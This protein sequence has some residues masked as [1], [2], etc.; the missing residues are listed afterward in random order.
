MSQ[1]RSAIFAVMTLNAVLMLAA[2][3][4]SGNEESGSD[5]INQR[6]AADLNRPNEKSTN[7]DITPK[8]P[9]CGS[10][11][12]VAEVPDDEIVPKLPSCDDD[13][14]IPKLPDAQRCPDRKICL[15]EGDGFGG[16][17]YSFTAVSDVFSTL[18]GLKFTD[19][20]AVDDN[21]SSIINNSD[22]NAKFYTDEYLQGDVVEVHS[23]AWNSKLQI[24]AINDSISSLSVG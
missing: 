16:Q 4:G 17:M 12:I 11:D 21:T 24:A 8:M 7:D 5:K 15:Y 14:I 6:A 2:C 20:V 10:G 3:G 1:T 18:R 9:E 22:F 23:H 13:E 19:D